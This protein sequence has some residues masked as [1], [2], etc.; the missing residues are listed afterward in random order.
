MTG[1][2]A[3]AEAKTTTMAAVRKSSTELAEVEHDGGNMPETVAVKRLRTEE[4][5]R[6]RRSCAE[7]AS[8]DI[9]PL[10]RRNMRKTR[11]R[12]TR[13]QWSLLYLLGH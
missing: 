2:A 8:F 4:H 10:R 7:D 9:A 12:S 13:L 6:E 5:R 3:A 1:E 11:F